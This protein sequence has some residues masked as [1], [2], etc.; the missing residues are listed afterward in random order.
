MISG[1]LAE[2]GNVR[3]VLQNPTVLK[4]VGGGEIVTDYGTYQL[5]ISTDTVKNY[6]PL[7]CH[8]LTDVAGPFDKHCLEEINSE[9]RATPEYKSLDRAPLPPYVGGSNVDLLLGIHAQVLPVHLFSLPSGIS[10]FK[11]PFTDIFGS[12]KCFGG[13]HKSFRKSATAPGVNHAAHVMS[14][15]TLSQSGT[16]LS[17]LYC[18]ISIENCFLV[19]SI[20]IQYTLQRYLILLRKI[21]DPFYL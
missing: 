9:L 15:F 14:A 20:T 13:T 3:V 18:V 2:K 7:I 4:V 17:R 19:K 1:E 16:C 6:Q 12:R 8:G 11:S 21:Q 10:V 5:N